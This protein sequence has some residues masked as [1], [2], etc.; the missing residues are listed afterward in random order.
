[1]D[2]LTYMYINN[3]YGPLHAAG[4]QII[5]CVNYITFGRLFY[6]N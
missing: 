5:Y 2:Q 1:M 6:E 3:V 4:K